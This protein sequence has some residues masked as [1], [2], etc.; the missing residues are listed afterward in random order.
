MTVDASLLH[1][2]TGQCPPIVWRRLATFPKA[3]TRGV[4]TDTYRNA[5]G[6]M[7]VV[8]HAVG[9]R[10]PRK[11]ARSRIAITPSAS[12]VAW[13]DSSVDADRRAATARANEP[14]RCQAGQPVAS[15]M[16]DCP[17][18]AA[19]TAR[20]RNATPP[21]TPA[22]CRHRARSSCRCACAQSNLLITPFTERALGP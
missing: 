14:C 4:A 16:D 8:S 22:S 3:S 15:A 19:T 11:P 12:A 2:V 21:Q 13:T 17:A 20:P 10:L 1:P 5:R 18:P 7:P 6:G 9:A